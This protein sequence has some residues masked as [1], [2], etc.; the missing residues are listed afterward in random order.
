ML[1]IGT[2]NIMEVE[3]AVGYSNP[4]HFA[5]VFKEKYGLNPRDFVRYRSQ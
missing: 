1:Q 4:S 2:M 5:E 3:N